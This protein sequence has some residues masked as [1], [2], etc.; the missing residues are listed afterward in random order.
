MA[1]AIVGLSLSAGAAAQP[2]AEARARA[3]SLFRQGRELL[4]EG[5]VAEACAKLEESQRIDANLATLLNLAHCHQ[6]QGKAASAW[7]EFRQVA[8]QAEAAGKPERAQY[9][10]ARATRL[11]GQLA[12]L[13]ISSAE[14]AA[15]LQ[16]QL[17][18]QAIGAGA[19]DAPLPVD[20]GD[21]RVEAW[22]PGRKRWSTTVR[23]R[24]GP[25]QATIRIP[26]LEAE[27]VRVTPS[28]LPPRS[29]ESAGPGVPAMVALGVGVAGIAAGAVFGGIALAE[30]AEA[31]ELCPD[32]ECPTQ[33]GADAHDEALRASIVS[34]AGFGVGVIGATVGLVLWLRSS[35]RRAAPAGVG[36]SAGASGTPVGVRVGG[37]W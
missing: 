35:S 32:V 28:T 1:L 22:A 13:T 16:V 36:V 23:I 11:E 30:E 17:D 37:V 21:R 5:R 3:E 31:D 26:L 25:S 15:G 20:P 6:E 2:P 19:M 8:A 12:R 7:A 27:P 9:A 33:E 4:A 24:P 34:T 18:G 10:S 14:R 29:R